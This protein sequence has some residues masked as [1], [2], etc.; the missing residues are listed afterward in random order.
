[1][2]KPLSPERSAS[3]KKRGTSKSRS[4]KPLKKHGDKFEDKIPTNTRGRA[5]SRTSAQR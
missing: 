1:M 5:K 2:A 4:P 3:Q